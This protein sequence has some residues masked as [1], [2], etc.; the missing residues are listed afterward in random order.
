MIGG[1][2]NRRH[3][4]LQLLW[5]FA[6]LAILIF[7]LCPIAPT[8]VAAAEQETP[9]ETVADQETPKEIVAKQIRRQG[10]ECGKAQSAERDHAASKPD[11]AVWVLSCDNATYRVRLHPDMAAQVELI[12]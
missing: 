5:C 6:C 3:H 9:K 7:V 10:Y 11:Q 2:M 12:K 8:P 1:T 4:V